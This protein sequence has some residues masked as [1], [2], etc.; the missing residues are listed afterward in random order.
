MKKIVL[1]IIAILSVVG[2]ARANSNVNVNGSFLNSG[3][4]QSRNSQ[5]QGH[6]GSDNSGGAKSQCVPEPAS[7]GAIAA[8]LIGLVSRRRKLK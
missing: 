8:G 4:S 7:I 6:Q 3:G 1:P 5:S 2:F